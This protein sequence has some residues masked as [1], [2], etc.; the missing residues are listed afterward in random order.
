MLEQTTLTIPNNL[1]YISIANAY[2]DS[3][4]Q[5]CGFPSKDIK[6][7]LMALEETL[8]NICKHAFESD[9]KEKIDISMEIENTYLSISIKDKGKPYD[10]MSGNE[11][12]PTMLDE[13]SDINVD[14]LSAFLIKN[15]VDIVSTANLGKLGNE[16]RLMISIPAHK[17]T[18]MAD[19]ARLKEIE[20]EA[21]PST[22]NIVEYRQIKPEEAIEVSRCIYTSYGR[23]YVNDALYYPEKVKEMNRNGSITSIVGL[24]ESGEIAG[25]IALI[26][27]SANST[28]V[29]WGIAVTKHKFRGKGLMNNLH[30]YAEKI[31][32]ETNYKGYFAHCVTEHPFTQKICNK[33]GFKDIAIAFGYSPLNVTYRKMAENLTQRQTIVFAYKY[34]ILSENTKLFLPNHHSEIITDLYNSLGLQIEP[35][36]L[37]DTQE[38]SSESIYKVDFFNNRNTAF[39]TVKEYGEDIVE[40]VA[41]EL[42]NACYEKNDI[43]FMNLDLR[44]HLTA[45]Y[46]EEFEKLGFVFAG[47]LPGEPFEHTLI[48]QYFN[49]IRFDYDKIDIY[50]EQAKRIFEYIRKYIKD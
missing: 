3:V 24:S 40:K 44:N 13:E 27:P 33:F 45:K 31:A 30:H 7:S 14:E 18:E 34:L 11:Y 19:M 49:N 28:I 1:T 39:I 15:N 48:L 16:L 4:M 9:D 6:K 42:K 26:R 50:S 2:A 17:I 37:N 22:E 8:T 41:F 5:K 25:H 23:S 32:I 29:E 35:Q 43:I 47:L 10:F 21:P 38:N 12:D 36:E 46:C 20:A